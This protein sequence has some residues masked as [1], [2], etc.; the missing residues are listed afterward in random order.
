MGKKSSNVLAFAA[1]REHFNCPLENLVAAT[2]VFP[3]TARLD[4]Q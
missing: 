4:L 3:P 1:L 2:R